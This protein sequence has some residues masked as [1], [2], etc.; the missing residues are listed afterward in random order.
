MR[1][2]V[3]VSR[4]CSLDLV[5]K[6]VHSRELNPFSAQIGC[7]SP[8]FSHQWDHLLSFSE[9]F[10]PYS[11]RLP[12]CYRCSDVSLQP[13]RTRETISCRIPQPSMVERHRN[14]PASFHFLKF[15][16]ACLHF[17]PRN[18]WTRVI[19]YRNLIKRTFNHYVDTRA[20]ILKA[21]TPGW[22]EVWPNYHTRK[23][24]LTEWDIT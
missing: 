21:V 2:Y 22:G 8:L 9:L 12:P 24:Q 23:N 20:H 17:T 5:R 3:G 15:S 7:Y 6:S 4:P 16:I 19:I 11:S 10:F 1:S 14:L 13:C 18:L